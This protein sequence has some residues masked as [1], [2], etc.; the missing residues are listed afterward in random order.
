M[1]QPKKKYSAF[2]VTADG[3]KAAPR[4]GKELEG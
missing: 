3:I 1:I 4:C 2:E